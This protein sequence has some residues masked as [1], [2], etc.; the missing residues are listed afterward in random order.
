VIQ[1]TYTSGLSVCA[2]P[3]DDNAFAVIDA[4]DVVV[5][6]VQTGE[7]TDTPLFSQV[8]HEC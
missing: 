4:V 6:A 1:V 3:R 2:W 7:E 8:N 5:G